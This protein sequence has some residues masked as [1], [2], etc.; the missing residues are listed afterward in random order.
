MSVLLTHVPYSTTWHQVC[1]QPL[2]S[3][4]HHCRCQLE[5]RWGDHDGC[6]V[7][8]LSKAQEM[9]EHALHQ[10]QTLCPSRPSHS[11]GFQMQKEAVLQSAFSQPPSRRAHTDTSKAY[12]A[13]PARAP[14]RKLR[15]C[16]NVAESEKKVQLSGRRL[17]ECKESGWHTGFYSMPCPSSWIVS[18]TRRVV[19]LWRLNCYQSYSFSISGKGEV[20]TYRLLPWPW[21][22]V[23]SCISDKEEEWNR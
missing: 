2:P 15:A 19:E 13:L 21:V 12:S 5:A 1:E 9:C 23:Y 16:L 3:W 17:Q 10:L 6:F 22:Y 11:F 8:G 18:C 7:P 20:P 4:C 14:H